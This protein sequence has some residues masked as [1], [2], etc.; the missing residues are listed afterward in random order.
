MHCFSS[1]WR[2]Q[3]IGQPCTRRVT[4]VPA[5]NS[6]QPT[7]VYIMAAV[8]RWV[9]LTDIDPSYWPHVL[10]LQTWGCF[11]FLPS[12]PQLEQQLTATL[13]ATEHSPKQHHSEYRWMNRLLHPLHPHSLFDV[14]ISGTPYFHYTCPL[15]LIKFT[16]IRLCYLSAGY[17]LVVFNYM[18]C[19]GNFNLPAQRKM[20]KGSMVSVLIRRRPNRDK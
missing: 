5:L 7:A 18:I 10:Y 20:K 12:D 11:F 6:L 19:E 13:V 4:A 9:I 2:A 8:L 3:G 1:A 15:E 14:L 16:V 17:E